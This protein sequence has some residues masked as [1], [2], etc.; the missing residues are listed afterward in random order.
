MHDHNRS[1]VGVHPCREFL[2]VVIF[3]EPEPRVVSHM[4]VRDR[5]V[6]LGARGEDVEGRTRPRPP[7]SFQGGGC[8]GPK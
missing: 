7:L 3:R 8:T 5:S 6:A 1:W 2:N 4:Q